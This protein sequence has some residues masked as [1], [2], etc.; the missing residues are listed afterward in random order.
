MTKNK[1]KHFN[2]AGFGNMVCNLSLVKDNSA[3]TFNNLRPQKTGKRLYEQKTLMAAK[4]RDCRRNFFFGIALY[5][6]A[7][8]IFFKTAH[9]SD[10]CRLDPWHFIYGFSISCMGGKNGSE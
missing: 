4:G 7:G 6:N 8:K 1:E 5:C 10:R 2:V 9:G 3:I